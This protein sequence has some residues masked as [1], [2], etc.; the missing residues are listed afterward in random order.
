MFGTWV[1]LLLILMDVPFYISLGIKKKWV[2]IAVRV[3]ASWIIAIAL[4]VL[5]FSLRK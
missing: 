5:A 1:S 4:L 3:L 2:Q